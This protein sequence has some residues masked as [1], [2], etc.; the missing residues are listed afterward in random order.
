LWRFSSK[1][2]ASA[3]WLQKS[4]AKVLP[5]NMQLKPLE[6]PKKSSYK[7]IFGKKNV[8]FHLFKEGSPHVEE[9]VLRMESFRSKELVN[10]GNRQQTHPEM[11]QKQ[12]LCHACV[13]M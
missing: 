1:V 6:I 4:L 8:S 9:G 12:R 5:K 2:L 3:W 11:P 10:H 13:Y 7:P